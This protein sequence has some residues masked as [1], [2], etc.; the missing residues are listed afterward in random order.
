M[1][2]SIVFFVISAILFVAASIQLYFG[3]PWTTMH[4]MFGM[5]LLIGGFCYGMSF[6]APAHRYSVELRDEEQKKIIQD[7]VHHLNDLPSIVTW[8]SYCSK[9]LRDAMA[10]KMNDQW[11]EDL[12]TQTAKEIGI[13]NTLVE[14]RQHLWCNGAGSKYAFSDGKKEVNKCSE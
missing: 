3:H 1:T 6:L 9:E 4:D 10:K 2:Q 13:D 7:I 5:V 8:R 11:Y 12:L 14:H